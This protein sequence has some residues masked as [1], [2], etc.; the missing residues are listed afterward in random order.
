MA[1]IRHQGERVRIQTIGY[2]QNHKPRIEG[3]PDG[4]SL[5]KVCRCVRMPVPMPVTM[6]AVVMMVVTVFVMR[7][8]GMPVFVTHGTTLSRAPNRRKRSYGA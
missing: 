2:L 8:V 3:Y 4:E 5:A 6:M 1:G 7:V